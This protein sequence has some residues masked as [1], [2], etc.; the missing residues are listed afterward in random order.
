MKERPIIM[1]PESVAA[2]LAGRKTQTLRVILP[3][4]PSEV[5]RAEACSGPDCGDGFHFIAKRGER[6]IC[7]WHTKSLYGVP[8]DRLWVRETWAT[9]KSF[10]DKSA[11]QIEAACLDAGYKKPG[12]PLWYSSMP[13]ALWTHR[14]WGDNDLQD[15]KGIGRARNA[16]FMPRW[17]SRITLELTDVRVERVQDISEADCIAEGIDVHGED[18]SDRERADERRSQYAWLW[19]S[20]NAKRGYPWSSNPWVWVLGFKRVEK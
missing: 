16:M 11:K 19:D 10:D 4:P 1:Q 13:G 5:L 12:A 15:F 6:E 2:I 14:P 17:V 20:I 18:L 9:G 7:E 8:G 3:Q